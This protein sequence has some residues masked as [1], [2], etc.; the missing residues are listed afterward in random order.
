MKSA[1]LLVLLCSAWPVVVVAAGDPARAVLD[2]NHAAVGKVPPTGTLQLQFD[3]RA[4][5]LSGTQAE[6]IDL[7]TGAYVE[8]QESGDIV[9][10]DGYDGRTPWQQD[11][12]RT[13]TTQRGGD[14]VPLAVNQAYRNA[15]AWWRA[16]AGG[17]D[18]AYIG[19]ETA[20]GR[21]FD[22]LAIAPVNGRRF[23]AWFDADTH[24]LTKIAEDRQFFH[25]TDAYSDYRREGDVLL[26]HAIVSDPGL[27]EDGI[28]RLTLTR[29]TFGPAQA[30]STYA[31]PTVAPAGASIIGGAASA[32]VPFRLL[33]NHVYVQATVN[34]HGP[35]TF[36][37]DS[38]GHT[39]LSSRIVDEAGLKTVGRAVQS[40]AGDGHST[41]GFVHFDELAIG[42]V[43]LRNQ[44]G[45]ASEIYDRSIEGVPVDGM[46][47]YELMR[48]LVTTIDY[49]ARTVTFTDPA[50]FT[51]GPDHG[52]AVTFEFYDHLPSVAGSL[53]SLPAVFNI[54]TGSRSELDMT[55]PIVA[56]RDL[57]SRYPKGTQAVTGYGVGGPARA[58]VVRVPSV[59][60]GAVEIRDVPTGLS[61]AKGGSF[62]DPNYD[63]NVGSALLKRFV[64]TFDYERQRIYLRRIVPTP[65]D[66]GTFDRSGL[67]I[68][69]KPGGYE[70]VDVA[71]DSAGSRAG[72]AV[73]DVVTAVDGKPVVVEE[74]SDVRRRLRSDPAG[75]A[76]ALTITQGDATRVVTITLADS[77]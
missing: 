10:G 66:V 58:Y 6:T 64:V 34:G 36:I 56:K 55:S 29:A 11:I 32:T 2:A 33:N 39:L 67:W 62:S 49:G 40:G 25:V 7:A 27:G 63:G 50:H 18:I 17:A 35:Y 73:G 65:P 9:G 5:G 31:M 41:T 45:F 71:R 43:R 16:D 52:D 28:S 53:D 38:G 72:L 44:T 57:R 37:V 30:S 70:I 12:S 20:D 42:D 59:K 51:P 46:V 19:R 75:T 68:N 8:N 15:N 77:I 23:D 74:L 13:Y 14:R 26:P 61:D 1:W 76:I 4:S 24:L 54:D 48:R 21:T 69:A 22:R 47:G 3:Y 60:L